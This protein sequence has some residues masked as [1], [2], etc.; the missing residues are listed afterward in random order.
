RR[1]AAK[2]V[3]GWLR[4]TNVW[5]RVTSPARWAKRLRSETANECIAEAANMLKKIVAAAALACGLVAPTATLVLS[6]SRCLRLTVQAQR[7]PSAKNH[8]VGTDAA[9]PDKPWDDWQH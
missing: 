7:W 4:R 3:P 5:R 8:L 6:L 9:S 1:A 2:L